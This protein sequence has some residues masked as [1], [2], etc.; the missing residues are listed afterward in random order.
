MNFY[1][2][3]TGVI[4]G[5]IL[6]T[7]LLLLYLLSRGKG[8]TMNVNINVNVPKLELEIKQPEDTK[9]DYTTVLEKHYE[10]KKAAEE[11]MTENYKEMTEIINDI[12]KEGIE[13]AGGTI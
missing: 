9:K 13:D 11:K 6:L 10:E 12:Y 4:L 2:V 1:E 3:F 8:L 7:F 5:G